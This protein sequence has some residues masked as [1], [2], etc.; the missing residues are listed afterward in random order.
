MGKRR[1][2]DENRSGPGQ[3][4]NTIQ[5]II[6][7]E[8]EN[9]NGILIATTNLEKNFDPAFER[10]FL[11][12]IEFSKPDAEIRKHIWSSMIPDLSDENALHLASH[13]NFSGGQIENITRKITVNQILSGNSVSLE[14]IT[15]FCDNENY[16]RKTTKIGFSVN[17]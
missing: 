17:S 1:L 10:R 3:T 13:F 7:S 15:R 4:E 9:L 12:K 2:L 5:N 8:M 14:D 6:L 11:Y 16:V